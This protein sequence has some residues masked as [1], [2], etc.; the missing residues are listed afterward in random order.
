[1]YLLI[2]ESCLAKSQIIMKLEDN[3]GMSWNKTEPTE[4]E[5]TEPWRIEICCS[6]IYGCQ[7]KLSIFYFQF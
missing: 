2:H 6:Y 4:N 7:S 5:Y 1:M 3:C